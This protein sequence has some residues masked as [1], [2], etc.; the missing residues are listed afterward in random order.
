MTA[1]PIILTIDTCLTQCSA[2]LFRGTSLLAKEELEM[3]RGHAE[4]L[5]PM[6]ER[7]AQAAD[8][9]LN[10]INLIC[11][12]KGPGSFAGQRVGITTANMMAKVL[13]KPLIGVSTLDIF[14]FKAEETATSQNLCVVIETKRKDFYCGFY[15][16][17]PDNTYRT[18]SSVR[19]KC[20]LAH[21]IEEQINMLNGEVTVTG[22]AAERLVKEIDISVQTSRHDHIHPEDLA[23]YAFKHAGMGV[24]T[25]VTPL[26][27]KDAD[28][29]EPKLKFF[30]PI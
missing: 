18:S 2:G 22:N 10:E 5:P 17:T 13:G 26:Y 29:S 8:I 25:S 1:Q 12:T 21:E 23:A 19:T 6:I 27:L 24:H 11:V 14:A 28:V 15:Q 4:N 9:S 16:F 30:Q 7:I 3:S 20:M